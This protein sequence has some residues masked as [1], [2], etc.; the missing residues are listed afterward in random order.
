[1]SRWASRRTIVPRPRPPL[2]PPRPHLRT[3][4]TRSD[5]EVEGALQE[6]R[7]E[8][9]LP[10]LLPLLPLLVPHADLS[11]RQ[12]EGTHRHDVQRAAEELGASARAPDR[13]P[14][15]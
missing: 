1:M 10:D 13:R 9:R 4:R 12:A 5:G 2:P 7:A 8:D 6:D 11:V 15:L 14:R 3:R